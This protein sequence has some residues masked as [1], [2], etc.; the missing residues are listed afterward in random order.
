MEG[1]LRGRG[2]DAALLPING[3]RVE[4][5]VAGN[6]WGREA[7]ALARAMGAGVAI[8]GHFEMFAFNTES[9]DEFVNE[10][11]RLGQAYRVMRAGEGIRV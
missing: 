2:V 4:R 6:L 7:A 8:P 11:Q 10:C 3:R 5:R 9:P 1:W